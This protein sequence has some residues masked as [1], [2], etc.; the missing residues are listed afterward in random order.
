MTK[1]V[2]ALQADAQLKLLNGFSL[3]GSAPAPTAL[4]PWPATPFY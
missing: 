2:C 3:K 1:G 4:S